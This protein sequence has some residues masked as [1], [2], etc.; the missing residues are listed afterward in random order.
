MTCSMAG[1]GVS[2]ISGRD[3]IGRRH[4]HADLGRDF[5]LALANRAR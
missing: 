4:F 2:D 1:V 5:G 3:A